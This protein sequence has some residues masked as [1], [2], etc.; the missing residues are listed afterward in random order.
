MR[1][2][3][4]ALLLVLAACGHE[5]SHAS[6]AGATGA[7]PDPRVEE[8][9]SAEPTAEPSLTAEPAAS[10]VVEPAPPPEG[11][12]TI[13][14]GIFLMG[15]RAHHGRPEDRPMHEVALAAFD[16]DRTEVT[17]RAYRAC[18]SRGACARPHEDSAY[19]NTDE[20]A[21][22]GRDDHPINC[23]D[24]NHAAAYCASVGKRLP[25]EPEWEYA[26]RGGAE[27]RHYSWGEEAPTS[28]IACY[29]HVGTCAVGSFKPGAFGLVDMSGNVWEWTASWF[30]PYPH[31]AREGE[32]RVYRGG[33]W[34]R[35]FPKWLD[36]AM[37]NRSAP[38]RWSASLGFRCARTRLPLACPDE[39]EARGEVCVRVRGVPGCE[40]NYAWNGEACT[41]A[42]GPTPRRGVD[43]PPGPPLAKQPVTRVR[44]PKQDADC[45]ARYRKKPVAYRYSGSTFHA[46]NKPLEKAGCTRRDMGLTW[47]SVCCPR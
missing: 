33:S 31:E 6:G 24:W 9:A 35:R 13:P 29:D 39:T 7:D 21:P 18:M 40:P 38:D 43:P 36:N 34:S 42:G 45:Q 46:R 15:S 30:G 27:L 41:I 11:M 3:A 12:I 5:P 25:T 26:A 22:P 23:V 19:C 14:T 8:H 20:R 47:T 37:R 32:V 17:T 4:V 28:E 16:L 10:A 1:L 44:T 2:R